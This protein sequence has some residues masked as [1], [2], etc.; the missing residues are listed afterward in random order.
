MGCYGN[1][2][3]LRDKCATEKL[4]LVLTQEP[5]TGQTCEEQILGPHRGAAFPPL[6]PALFRSFVLDTNHSLPRCP[7]S[8][9]ASVL[10]PC[11][12]MHPPQPLPAAAGG[13]FQQ[14][15]HCSPPVGETSAPLLPGSQHPR[16]RSGIC[17]QFLLG[18]SQKL[19]HQRTDTAPAP[20]WA[21]WLL[22]LQ[23][24]SFPALLPKD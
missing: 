15:Q 23:P 4:V 19:L 6:C 5:R 24:G 8:S 3:S 12:E 14:E 17:P 22:L 7:S 13:I 11:H 10:Q 18:S 20:S 21:L 9:P 1:S 2:R 16:S